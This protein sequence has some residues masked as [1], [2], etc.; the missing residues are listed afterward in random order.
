MTETMTQ[1]RASTITTAP[2]E[3]ALAAALESMRRAAAEAAA[4]GR[5]DFYDA[6]TTDVLDH[7]PVIFV[8][9]A[10]RG[11][12]MAWLIDPSAAEGV[13]KAHISHFFDLPAAEGRTRGDIPCVATRE[14]WTRLYDS[15][16][17]DVAWLV[18]ERNGSRIRECPG[19]WPETD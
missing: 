14:S 1:P 13:L 18:R 5:D 12:T 7:Q 16:A 4:K 9:A 17:E 3:Q 8:A 6:W 2:L 11:E 15:V 19:W 10:L